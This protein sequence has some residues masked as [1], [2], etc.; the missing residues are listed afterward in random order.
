M[1]NKKYL[2]FKIVHL[3]L[4]SMT[5][6]ITLVGMVHMVKRFGTGM[7]GLLI[8]RLL[9]SAV[10]IMAMAVGILYLVSGY[11]KSSA[12]YY[13]LFFC[14]MIIALVL[15]LLVFITNKE[16]AVMLLGGILTI[17]LACILMAGKDLGRN[18]S[19]AFLVSLL[20][21]EILLM[22]PIDISNISFGQ[23]GGELSMFMLYGTAAFMVAAKYIDKSLRGTK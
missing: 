8:L 17:V 23:L 10:R 22:L 6:V 20:I 13:K 4:M 16:S 14:L 11:K 15:R 5:T 18:K 9:S 21:I 3:I 12:K 7:D 19:I 2:P 1:E